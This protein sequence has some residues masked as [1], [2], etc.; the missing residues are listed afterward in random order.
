MAAV[1]KYSDSLW[2][3]IVAHSGNDFLSFMLFH[4]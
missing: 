1:F 3:A 2:A 4:V